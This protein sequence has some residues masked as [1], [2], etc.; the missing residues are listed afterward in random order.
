MQPLDVAVANQP[1]PKRVSVKTRERQCCGTVTFRVVW[2]TYAHQLALYAI[3]NVDGWDHT[4]AFH[5]ECLNDVEFIGSDARDAILNV[6]SSCAEE[7][8]TQMKEFPHAFFHLPPGRHQ[9]RWPR[10]QR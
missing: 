5:V 6:W 4:F 2:E 7:V 9:Q 10:G 8:H 1:E 3:L